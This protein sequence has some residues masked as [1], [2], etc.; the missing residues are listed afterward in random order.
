M[1]ADAT[2]SAGRVPVA[3]TYKLAIGGAFPRSESGRSY[4]VTDRTGRFLANAS[5]ASR[6]DAR[7]AVSAAAKA[8][9]DWAGRTAMNR[10]QIL[11]RLAEMLETRRDELAARVAEAEGATDAEATALVDASV[12]RWVW[13]AGWAD[14]L[15]HALGTA[16]PVSG[17]FFNF[18]SP[19]PV[20]V[21]AV[22]APEASSLLGLTSVLA[23]VLASGNV[24]VV[25]A[26]EEGP[27]PA[28]SLAEAAATAD[29]PGGVINVL[30]GRQA[31]LVPTLAAHRDVQGLDLAGVVDAERAAEW[32]RLSADNL[33]RV[34]RP[35]SGGD[36]AW[37]EAPGLGRLQAFLETKTVWHP[38]GR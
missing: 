33:K 8:A 24:A 31:E 23:P 30:T 21:V 13:Y 20:G 26:S 2:G 37:R 5:L 27:L 25:V 32:E 38:K 22:V 10:G 36:A 4:A 3:K 1:S 16:N 35:V 14:K 9:P 11:Y 17:P 19:E 29:L 34:S 18:S 15:A 6:K 28:I 12:D 7:D